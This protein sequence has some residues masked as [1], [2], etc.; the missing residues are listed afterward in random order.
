MEFCKCGSIIKEGKCSN[1]HCTEKDQKRKDRIVDGMVMD[2]KKPVS[3]G[4]AAGLAKRMR[5]SE[6]NL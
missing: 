3:F 5:D 6:H 4:E 1:A 2:F